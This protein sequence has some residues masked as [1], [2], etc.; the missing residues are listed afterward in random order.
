VRF[1]FHIQQKKVKNTR[2]CRKS[3]ALLIVKA[4]KAYKMSNISN[5][6]QYT[7]FISDV[8]ERIRSAQYEALR[9]VNKRQIDL[10]WYL[11]KQIVE[12]Q[13]ELGWGKSVVEQ[14][15]KDIQSTFPLITGFSTRNLWL[16]RQFY[17]MYEG[18][19]ILQPLV[20][21]IGWSHHLQIMSKC[22]SDQQIRSWWKGL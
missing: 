20:A 9:A 2:Y 6:S 12:K 19:T 5:Q 16:M 1:V 10:Y 22:D 21:E 4:L 3:I 13:V 8:L 18:S 7:D 17:E 14:M 11:G 15:S